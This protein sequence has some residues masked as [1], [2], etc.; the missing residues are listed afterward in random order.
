MFPSSE[1]SWRYAARSAQYPTWRLFKEEISLAPPRSE[2]VRAK[3]ETGGAAASEWRSGCGQ[4][5]NGHPNSSAARPKEIVRVI[6]SG[7][8]SA[9]NDLGIGAD[10]HGRPV[11]SWP[12]FCPHFAAGD[13]VMGP[14]LSVHLTRP[15]PASASSPPGGCCII[16]GTQWRWFGT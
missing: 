16:T 15:G 9:R 10:V 2:I 8:P 1:G 14:M 4:V 13:P 11:R 12:R 3:S 7:P 5:Q 6:R